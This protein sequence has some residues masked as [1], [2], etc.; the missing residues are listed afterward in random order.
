MSKTIHYRDEGAGLV[1]VSTY[2]LFG[3]PLLRIERTVRA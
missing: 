3:I 2:R 1:E